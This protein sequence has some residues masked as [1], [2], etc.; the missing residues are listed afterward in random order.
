MFFKRAGVFQKS[1]TH[2][3]IGISLYLLNVRRLKTLKAVVERS[4]V[5]Y[6]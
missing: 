4:H 1:S 6:S 2:A 3:G 5:N